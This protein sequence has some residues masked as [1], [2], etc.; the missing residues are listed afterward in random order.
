MPFASQT[1]LSTFAYDSSPWD[2]LGD[3][4]RLRALAYARDRYKGLR[5]RLPRGLH[6]KVIR[7]SEYRHDPHVLQGEAE[8]WKMSMAN[9]H[10]CTE[11]FGPSDDVLRKAVLFAEAEEDGLPHTTERLPIRW[12]ESTQELADRVGSAAPSTPVRISSETSA[13]DWILKRCQT[14]E[15]DHRQKLMS[16]DEQDIDWDT[17]AEWEVRVPGLT[18]DFIAFLGARATPGILGL[19]EFHSVPRALPGLPVSRVA[20]ARRHGGNRWI[21]PY[22]PQ[23]SD[24]RRRGS[25]HRPLELWTSFGAANTERYEVHMRNTAPSYERVEFTDSDAWCTAEDP[26]KDDEDLIPDSDAEDRAEDRHKSEIAALWH[27]NKHSDLV[28]PQDAIVVH[29]TV[30]WLMAFG[31]RP[32]NGCTMEEL[33]RMT[34]G[35]VQKG[36]IFLVENLSTI[37][38][39]RSEMPEAMQI[40]YAPGLG[41]YVVLFHDSMYMQPPYFL[42]GSEY[43]DDE[44]DAN[45]RRI[46]GHH[47]SM[48]A[49][50]FSCDVFLV[51][52]GNNPS[53]GWEDHK[54]K[55]DKARQETKGKGKQRRFPTAPWNASQPASSQDVPEA[56]PDS[57]TESRKKKPKRNKS[58]APSVSGAQSSGSA[59]T[60]DVTGLTVGDLGWAADPRFTVPPST[61]IKMADDSM[62]QCQD[63]GAYIIEHNEK[64]EALSADFKWIAP[65]KDSWQ[66]ADPAS[67]WITNNPMRNGISDRMLL[68]YEELTELFKNKYNDNPK[69]LAKK[70]EIDLDIL[71]G[72]FRTA[73]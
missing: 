10:D 26:I 30:P 51:E 1:S 7:Q 29:V 66:H 31:E 23:S 21:P 22:D 4:R 73:S 46:A 59:G 68:A 18:R 9:D 11:A 60:P 57:T 70:S 5:I 28:R 16:W 41:M 27:A 20:V 34:V 19:R 17:G 44:N 62:V 64:V 24:P 35:I 37:V 61:P 63:T 50:V 48:G 13:C 69:V 72:R 3:E 2:D 45:T 43:F 15:A 8:E 52:E 65:V 36:A 47:P 58:P 53:K 32:D 71:R 6:D 54:A 38:A 42:R 55:Q 14:T 12:T 33:I 40:A 39:Y 56:E 25:D 67:P 49:G